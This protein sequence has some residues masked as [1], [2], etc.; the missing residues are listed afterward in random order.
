M[1]NVY[2]GSNVTILSGVT[3]CSNVVVAAGAVVVSDLGSG[4]V[5]GGVPAKQLRPLH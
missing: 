5:Y 3:I 2:I 1:D 4:F